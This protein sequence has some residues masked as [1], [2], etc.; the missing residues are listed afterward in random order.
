MVDYLTAQ[1]DRLTVL[2]ALLLDWHDCLIRSGCPF[3]W[4]NQSVNRLFFWFKYRLFRDRLLIVNNNFFFLKKIL[5]AMSYPPKKGATVRTLRLTTLHA[6]RTVIIFSSVREKL[7]FLKK[8]RLWMLRHFRPS[9]SVS[10][11]KYLDFRLF[12]LS[13]SA[14]FFL[15]V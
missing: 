1:G 15:S 7:Q 13:H 2:I 3:L 5:T 8:L 12:W 14:N 4:S 11:A 6:V 10:R 9:D